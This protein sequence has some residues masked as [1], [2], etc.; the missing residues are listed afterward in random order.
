MVLNA[1]KA[2]A[3]TFGLGTKFEI[4]SQESW[5][6]VYQQLTESFEETVNA[7]ALLENPDGND[8]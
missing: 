6:T 8:E 3:N 2:L 5:T 1:L 4:W 7:V